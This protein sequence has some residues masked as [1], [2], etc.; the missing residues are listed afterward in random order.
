M[1]F[2]YAGEMAEDNEFGLIPLV[3]DFDD[4]NGTYGEYVLRKLNRVTTGQMITYTFNEPI[5]NS[6]AERFNKLTNIENKLKEV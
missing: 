1:A 3:Y 5:A 2:P 4:H 6:I